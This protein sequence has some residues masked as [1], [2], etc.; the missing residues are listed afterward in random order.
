MVLAVIYEHRWLL[1]ARGSVRDDE[2]SLRKMLYPSRRTGRREREKAPWHMARRA[3]REG[4]EVGGRVAA[5]APM[6]VVFSP[7]ADPK[8]PT[9]RLLRPRVPSR[10]RGPP[11]CCR[12]RRLGIVASSTFSVRGGQY[13]LK[14]GQGRLAP[15][16]C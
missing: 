1:L 11:P 2:T 15:D 9:S 10:G 12:V 7:G 14:L 6:W 4:P 13:D 5:T 3:C 16:E 8:P